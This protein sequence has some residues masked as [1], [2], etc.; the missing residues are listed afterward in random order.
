MILSSHCLEPET[1]YKQFQIYLELGQSYSS[2]LGDKKLGESLFERAHLLALDHF[3]KNS[4]VL[5]KYFAFKTLQDS[6]AE[7]EEQLSKLA[8][9]NYDIVQLN[10][11]TKD[12]K[13]SMFCLEALFVQA[14][15]LGEIDNKNVDKIEEI[16]EKMQ[17]ICQQIKV[18]SNYL[19][20]TQIVRAQN[21]FLFEYEK[22]NAD[23]KSLLT[24]TMK[25]QAAGEKPI[26]LLEK[27]Y[28]QTLKQV[29][30]NQILE[31]EELTME[32]LAKVDGEM[33]SHAFLDKIT[34]Q[35]AKNYRKVHNFGKATEFYDILIQTREQTYGINSFNL[36][37][38]LEELAIT[39]EIQGK[40]VDC[41]AIITSILSIL[42][43]ILDK[44]QQDREE[45]LNKIEDEVKQD[46]LTN[47][48]NQDESDFCGKLLNP[49]HILLAS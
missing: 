33:R 32:N 12:G 1:K 19:T 48:T 20:Q 29:H 41:S 2:S 7:N 4:A 24:P 11:P 5:Q 45:D 6:L 17:Q 25:R 22:L 46:D 39:C 23:E 38:P 10:N 9:D 47:E 8:Q 26:E 36:L 3:G 31:N 13:L 14:S 42:S 40:F 34:F 43:K 16:E 15:I 18:D 27:A 37:R 28:L 21:L 49:E 44:D 35:L 30:G